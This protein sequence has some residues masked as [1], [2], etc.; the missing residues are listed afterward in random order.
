MKSQNRLH[1]LLIASA[2]FQTAPVFAQAR[3]FPLPD[4][5][6][7]KPVLPGTRFGVEYSTYELERHKY[8]KRTQTVRANGEFAFNDYVSIRGDLPWTRKKETNTE[9]HTRFDNMGLGV[10]LAN[11]DGNWI[12]LGGLDFTL[13][14][15]NDKVG[16][17]SKRIFN[18]EPFVGV[19]YHG[20][21]FSIAAIGRYNSQANRNFKEDATKKDDFERAWVAN[22][23]LGLSFTYLDLLLEY[24]YKYLYDPDPKHQSFHSIAPGI[25]IKL[26]NFMLG[27]AVP[28]AMSKDR[29]YDIGAIVRIYGRF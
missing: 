19:G 26:S 3:S 11:P 9:T 22:L 12:P 16:I 28:Y 14:T 13:A 24:Q 27:F 4:Y 6:Y 15:G 23:N 7:S 21:M 10:H 2:L 20:D 29:P 5:I 8:Y 17:G 25:N 18:V 1:I